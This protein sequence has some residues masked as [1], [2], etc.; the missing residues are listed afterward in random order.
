MFKKGY[1][2]YEMVRESK[3]PEYIQT[4]TEF[5]IVDMGKKKVY[6]SFNLTLKELSDKLEQD[7][8]FIVKEATYI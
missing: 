6:S 8:V 4:K 7:N 2:K 1:A 3:V 5:F